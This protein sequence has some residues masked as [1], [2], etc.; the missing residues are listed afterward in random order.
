M[1]PYGST[2]QSVSTR[3][4]ALIGG[5]ALFWA[6]AETLTGQAL[7]RFQS[8][9]TRKTEPKAFWLEVTFHYCVGLGLVT[10]A[11]YKHFNP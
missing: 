4:I 7:R 8:S 3:V 9:V 2:D 5:F 1:F 6:T 10:Y 11:T